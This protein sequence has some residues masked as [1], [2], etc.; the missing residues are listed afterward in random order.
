MIDQRGAANP[1]RSRL[2]A[3]SAGAND[4]PKSRLKGGCSP[5]WLPPKEL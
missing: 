3:G 4:A 5:D 2:L 1:G